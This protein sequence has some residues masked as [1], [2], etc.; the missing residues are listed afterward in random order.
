[1]PPTIAFQSRSRPVT[2]Y[3]WVAFDGK[4]GKP[5]DINVA[6]DVPEG[7]RQVRIACY[8]IE[9]SDMY[10]GGIPKPIG[11]ALLRV[12]PS[13]ARRISCVSARLRGTAASPITIVVT[14]ADAEAILPPDP[15]TSLKDIHH[16]LSAA[17]KGKRCDPRIR[18]RIL[19]LHS[20]SRGESLV[21]EEPMWP[22]RFD[23]FRCSASL[24][25][26]TL[27]RAARVL[28]WLDPTAASSAPHS[29]AANVLQLISGPYRM[30][31]SE[32]YDDWSSGALLFG[33]NRD[34]EDMARD[35]I[36]W[37]RT[38]RRQSK[39]LLHMSLHPLSNVAVRYVTN[40]LQGP[41]HIA[42]CLADPHLA[43]A[44]SPPAR[45]DLSGHAFAVFEDS[46]STRPFV[47]EA[48]ALQS[49]YDAG[50]CNPKQPP[51]YSKERPLDGRKYCVTYALIGDAGIGLLS[52]AADPVTIGVS[53]PDLISGQYTVRNVAPETPWLDPNPMIPEISTEGYTP[54]QFFGTK[55]QYSR[56][57]KGAARL[58]PAPSAANG[59]VKVAG[60]DERV[61]VSKKVQALGQH[62]IISP[63]GGYWQTAL[64]IAKPP[65]DYC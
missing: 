42:L 10:P 37:V 56:V 13:D 52:P 14:G 36:C 54:P 41:E 1:M 7:V 23:A 62:F 65:L 47:L 28:A 35:A 59:Q 16:K 48:T 32:R 24:T 29:I 60:P 61:T 15:T 25:A 38:I 21:K 26:D 20:V 4:S 39:A 43:Y 57:L 19:A 33:R 64:A 9:P 50:E 51:G 49:P 45:A 12:A 58:R 27:D 40:R 2:G 34:C 3:A 17:I 44:G 55:E 18:R 11:S 5:F 31:D 8:A 46:A 53:G 63:A 6:V 30:E 22:P